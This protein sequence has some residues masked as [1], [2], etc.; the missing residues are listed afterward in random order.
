MSWVIWKATVCLHPETPARAS[1]C[2]MVLK[3]GSFYGY[4]Y[5]GV[6]EDGNIMVFKDGIKGGETVRGRDASEADRTYIGN[7]TPKWGNGLGKHIYL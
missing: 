7:G 2:R 1:V 6:D 4:R 3:S 5:A